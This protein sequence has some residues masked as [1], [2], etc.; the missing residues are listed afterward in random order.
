MGLLD[1]FNGF[2]GGT[3]GFF[4]GYSAPDPSQG[5]LGDMY[6]TK[7]LSKAKRKRALLQAGLAMMAQGPSQ[8]PINMITSLGQGLQQGVQG[9]NEYEDQYRKQAMDA[10][11]VKRLAENDQYGRERDKMGD[12][13]WQQEFDYRQQSD[14]QK[15][16]AERA[17]KEQAAKY[18]LNPQWAYNPVTK[19]WAQF[20]PNQTGGPPSMVQYPEG[21]EPMP[22]MS[23]QDT[24][25]NIVPMTT[26]GAIPGG[27]AIPIQNREKNV[28]I[29]EGKLQ[30]EA[31]GMLPGA[32]Q[33][34]A[35]TKM[36]IDDVANN[37]N[38]DKALG[39]TSWL[40]DLAVSNEVIE[41]R[42]KVKELMGG[43]FLE[44]RAMLKGGGAITD[45]ESGR[46]EAAYS[47]LETAIKSSDPAV[48]KEALADF[49]GA[50]D[51]GVAK[52]EA[53]ATGNANIGAQPVPQGQP[54]NTGGWSIRKVK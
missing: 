42:G 50:I 48:F 35:Y 29:E 11:G 20:Q 2:S 30:G 33:S 3:G 53:T 1:A 9:A 32:K 21:Y 28:Q 47:R 25:T 16:A 46:A 6:D 37:P 54:T 10:Y 14:A 12:E 40:G 34:A 15:L 27:P 39:Y 17:Q 5:L 23:Y 41:V 44:A 38:L 45:Y 4:D 52:L 24:G 43:A 8:Y 19:K 18:G 26:R 31:A 13:R 7:A 36:K 51:A 22:T 49:K